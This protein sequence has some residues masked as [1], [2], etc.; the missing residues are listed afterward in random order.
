MANMCDNICTS[1]VMFSLM[2]GMTI[3]YVDDYKNC[4]WPYGWIRVAFV[5][6]CMFLR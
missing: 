1:L 5:G 4:K 3:Y 6:L 2:L